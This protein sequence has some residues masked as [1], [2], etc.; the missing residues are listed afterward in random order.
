MVKFKMDVKELAESIGV[1]APCA[2]AQK[3]VIKITLLNKQTK[4]RDAGDGKLIMFL[5]Y[6]EKKQ[7]ATFSTAREV[8]MEQETLEMYVDGKS[9]SS[10]AAILGQR[11]GYASFEVDKHMSVDGGNSRIDFALLDAVPALTKE[12]N[13][14]YQIHMNTPC[15]K[16]ILAR[17][18]YAYLGG[19]KGQLNLR[20]V[21]MKLDKEAKTITVCSSNGNMIAVDECE[22]AAFN[23]TDYPE[24][25]HTILIE[26]EQLKAVMKTLTDEK[27]LLEVYENQLLFRSGLN[28]CLLRTADD[29]Y[30]TESLLKMAREQERECEIKVSVAEL[31]NAIDIF[32]IARTG[33]LPLCIIKDLG[34]NRI[35]LQ[36]SQGNGRTEIQVQKKNAF[37]EVAFNADYFKSIIN[38]YDKGAEIFLGIGTPD[39]IIVIKKEKE[40]AGISCLLPVRQN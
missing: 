9:F 10:L 29:T 4:N 17:G 1:I 23:D 40:Y 33:N 7:I 6:D 25:S 13:T 5:C 39:E 27:T 31:L 30:P 36:T 14:M 12:K 8:Q 34:N 28:I 11:E 21:A 38:N 15:L 18:G 37:T 32:H 3:S 35:C 26:G 20:Y 16:A 19:N 22:D 2:V 24:N